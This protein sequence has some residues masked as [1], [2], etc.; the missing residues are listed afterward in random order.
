MEHT[1]SGQLTKDAQSNIMHNMNIYLEII[2]ESNFEFMLEIIVVIIF[3][4]KF[5]KE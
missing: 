5:L 2:P 4:D 1:V 3:E